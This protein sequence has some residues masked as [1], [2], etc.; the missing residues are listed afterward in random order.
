MTFGALQSRA[1]DPPVL[2]QR[3]ARF[4]APVPAKHLS[5]LI[6]CDVRTA[7]NMKRGHWPIARHWAGLI[8]AFGE[9]V[10][11][12]VFHP[13]KATE[14]LEREVHDLEQQLARKRAA[15]AEGPSPQRAETGP[16]TALGA[17]RLTDRPH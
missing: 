7:E 14:R 13:H 6:G 17:G 9:D 11:E 10:T 2:S 15:L 16:A 1:D 3:L 5:R 4:V 12:A 8:R